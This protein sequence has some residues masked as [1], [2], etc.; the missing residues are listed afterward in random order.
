MYTVLSAESR[1][2]TQDRI[3]AFAA[4]KNARLASFAATDAVF[5]QPI[6]H[7]KPWFCAV[8]EEETEVTE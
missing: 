4:N 6:A 7:A 5:N 8:M 2:E 3:N 1:Q